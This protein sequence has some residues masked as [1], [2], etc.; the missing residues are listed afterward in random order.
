[1]RSGAHAFRR[2]TMCT[3]NQASLTELAQIATNCRRTY[4]EMLTQLDDCEAISLF[5]KFNQ[6]LSTFSVE[7]VCTSSH[8]FMFVCAHYAAKLRI[9]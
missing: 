2:A 9:P 8:P 5:D 7:H 1:M 3:F 6:L 4:A